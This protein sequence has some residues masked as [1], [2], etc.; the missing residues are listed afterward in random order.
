MF[1]CWGLK[2]G[3]KRREREEERKERRDGRRQRDMSNRHDRPR[4][5]GQ[6]KY[7]LRMN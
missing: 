3:T 4:A 2:V 5:R 6:V 1:L 7:P